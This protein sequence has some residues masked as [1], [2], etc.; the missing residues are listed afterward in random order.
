MSKEEK[1]QQYKNKCF[2]I[3]PISDQDGYPEGHF[4]KIYKQI[5]YPSIQ[6]A[7]Y[8]PYRVDSNLL[9]QSIMLEIFM[10]IQECP[11]AVCDL[12]ARNPNVL[13]ELGLRQAYDKP[14]V[15]IK[16]EKTPK[17]FDVSGLNT[18]EYNSQRLYE[19]VL[20]AKEKIKKAII[21]TKKSSG[22]NHSI[23]KLLNTS[24]AINEKKDISED[25]KNDLRLA[26][27]LEKINDVQ[28][29]LELNKTN[30]TNASVLN[31]RIRLLESAINEAY[32]AKDF[33]EETFIK[34][35]RTMR[36]IDRYFS[37]QSPDAQSMLANNYNEAQ[38]TYA[39]YRELYQEFNNNKQNV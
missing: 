7:G 28:N 31:A 32:A 29:F 2:V 12:S 23:V 25:D 18:H 30:P 1:S 5:I 24:K 35:A 14:V 8:D 27:I 11:M 6:D 15:L 26:V 36:S 3:M 19:N 22:N 10:A 4:D 9:S 17:I 20:D 21:E 16:D 13:Y 33:G 37:I 39:K 34:I 38:F